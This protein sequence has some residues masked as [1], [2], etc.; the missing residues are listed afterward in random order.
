MGMVAVS[1]LAGSFSLSRLVAL[2]E[3]GGGIGSALT[4]GLTAVFYGLLVWAYL[5]RG[6]ANS[7]S[8]VR[9]AL[10]AAP[11]AT[12]LPFGLPFL[13]TGDSTGSLIISDGLM[14]LGLTWSVWS[15]K[16]L[17]RSISIVPQAR[18][19]VDHGP[20][21]KV[22]HPLYLGEIVTVLGFALALGGPLPLVGWVLLVVLQAYR[23]TQEELLLGTAIPEY[24]AYQLRTSRILPGV[25]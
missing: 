1:V 21:R 20:Y 19:L 2:P 6:P 17:D 15:L 8:Q 9:S 7:T 16:S 11:V 24:R 14:V 18:K 13:G 4:A 10:V 3:D 22:R 25:F 5:R 12:F 23:A